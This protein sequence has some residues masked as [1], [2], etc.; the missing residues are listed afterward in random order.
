MA[1]EATHNPR[2][3]KEQDTNKIFRRG[4]YAMRDIRKGE[5]FTKQNV[6]C[7]RPYLL[8]KLVPKDLFWT[9]LSCANRDI[10]S[11]TALSVDMIDTPPPVDL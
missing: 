11:G 6:G 9:L 7:F 2:Y 8:N 3:S 1:W 5:H 4:L 10:K